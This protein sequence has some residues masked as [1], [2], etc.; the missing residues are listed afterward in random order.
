MPTTWSR[1]KALLNQP[2][3]FVRIPRAGGAASASV[4][5]DAGR[6]GGQ[7]A[8][9][10]CRPVRRAWLALQRRRH[11]SGDRQDQGTRRGRGKRP[12]RTHR[13]PKT[14]GRGLHKGRN[15]PRH[16]EWRPAL[17]TLQQPWRTK[18]KAPRGKPRGILKSNTLDVSSRLQA[19]CPTRRL[20]CK[21]P[22]R[23]P[24]LQPTQAEARFGASDPEGMKLHVRLRSHS[25]VR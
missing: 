14:P 1:I 7:R 17:S 23:A 5:I 12:L 16:V 13:P 20:S 15:R 10:R 22:G 21:R 24:G 18:S 25:R 4:S 11:G 8:V 2:A 3:Q 9:R 6:P 19:G